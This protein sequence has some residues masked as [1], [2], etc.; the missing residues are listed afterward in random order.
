[1]T[2]PSV[3]N[4]DALLKSVR[5]EHRSIVEAVLKG[6]T[7]QVRATKPAD[8]RAAYVWRNVVFMVSRNSQHQCMPAMADFYLEKEHYAHR[9]ERYEPR[10]E[11]E[12]DRA[13]IARWDAEPGGREGGRTWLM[14]DDGAKRRAYMKTELDPLV[15][16]IVDSIPKNQWAGVYRWGRA[17]GAL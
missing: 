11:S 15:D 17:L 1:M 9:P 16:L 12:N 4:R 6:K 14:M 5:P 7:A 10:G 2:M 13:T 8:G 3:L